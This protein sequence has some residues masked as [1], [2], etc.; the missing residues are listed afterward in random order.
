LINWQDSIQQQHDKLTSDLNLI[1]PDKLDTV[2]QNKLLSI[3]Q[4]LDKITADKSLGAHNYEL[5]S[6]ILEEF[7]RNVNQ[8]LD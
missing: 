8:M 2:N 1:D 6:R 4:G 3:Q 5:I 7:Q